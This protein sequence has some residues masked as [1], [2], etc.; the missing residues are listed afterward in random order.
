MNAKMMLGSFF[1]AA[2]LLW[3]ALAAA[4]QLIGTTA[5]PADVL[6]LLSFLASAVLAGGILFIYRSLPQGV[7]ENE[8]A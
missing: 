5:T 1:H 8:D 6:V 2:L 4:A 7:M 3:A